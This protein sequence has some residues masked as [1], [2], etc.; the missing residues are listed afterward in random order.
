MDETAVATANIDLEAVVA[1]KDT[2]LVEAREEVEKVKVERSD[3]KARIVMAYKDDF[4]NRPEYM[5][6]GNHFMT[7]GGEQLVEWIGKT[8]LEWEILFSSI[9]LMTF[10]P[11]RILQPPKFL[12]M[13]SDVRES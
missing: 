3:A 8:Y 7:A 13:P 11:Q 5:E 10:L 9:L 2:Q 4:E 1:E 6:L 12:R